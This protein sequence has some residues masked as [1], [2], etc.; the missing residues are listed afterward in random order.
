MVKMKK[1]HILTTL[2]I[3]LVIF[4]FSS[5]LWATDRS[6]DILALIEKGAI[7]KENQRY[8]NA[9]QKYKEAMAIVE[10]E[11]AKEPE[12]RRISLLKELLEHKIEQC[13]A[14]IYKIEQ[15]I[16]PQFPYK[17]ELEKV[18]VLIESADKEKNE[19]KFYIALKKYT[20]AREK[21]KFI[22]EN[23]P[24]WQEAKLL[25]EL[26]ERRIISSREEIIRLEGRS[27]Q[28]IAFS[29]NIDKIMKIVEKSSI[30]EKDDK[31]LIALQGYL[32]ALKMLEN[33]E[34]DYPH[35]AA[36]ISL[37]K[38]MVN[39]RIDGCRKKIEK[40]EKDIEEGIV[41]E[42]KV[43]R[44]P[45]PRAAVKREEIRPTELVEKEEEI[46]AEVE[47]EARVEVVVLEKPKP[48]LKPLL[49]ELPVKKIKLPLLKTYAKK[50]FEGILN[51]VTESRKAGRVEA[52]RANLANRQR[53]ASIKNGLKGLV[54]AIKGKI[55]EKIL[56]VKQKLGDFRKTILEK[57][58]VAKEKI[59]IPEE[60]KV[61]IPEKV[62]PEEVKP[63]KIVVKPEEVVK[64]EVVEE[65][66]KPE[67]VKEVKRPPREIGVAEKKQVWVK[68]RKKRP[69]GYDFSGYQL[70]PDITFYFE[71]KEFKFDAPCVRKGDEIWVPVKEFTGILNLVCL[72]LSKTS[73]GII[74]DDGT[75]LEMNL[76]ETDVLVN[77]KPF[78][79]IPRPLAIY[80][81]NFMLSLD[82]LQE[83]VGISCEYA[84][85]TNVVTITR[86]KKPKFTTFTVEKPPVS[87][88]EE[89]KRK[90]RLELIK[91]PR[92][93]REMREE[94]LP[95]EYYP[96]IDMKL[97]TS[98]RYFHD[99]LAE[100]RTRYNEYDLKGK[101]YGV[102]VFGHLSMRDYE[103]VEKAIWKEDGQHLS[104]FKEGRGLKL[105]D[106]Y[107]RLPGVR[108][109]SQSYWGA[110]LSDKSG[111]IKNA[112][113]GEMDSVYVSKIDGTGSVKYSGN[114]YAAKQD[115]ID[116][117]DFRLSAVELFTH[118]SPQFSEDKGTT[119]HPR[120]N[121]LYLL[122]TN[123]L[124]R[125]ALNLYNTFA[126]CTYVPDN[127]EDKIVSDYDIKTGM[128]FKHER[129]SVNSSV[130]YVG[131]KYASLGIPSTYQDYLG[132]Q[133]STNFKLMK[134][135]SLNISGN[136]NRD[137]VAFNEDN[138]TTHGRG[139]STSTNLRLPWDQ[140]VS[141]GW[142]YNR[143]ITRGG[144]Q[145]TTGNEYNSY[146]MDYYKTL[147]TASLQLGWQY[148]RMDPLAT[149]TG[150]MLFHTYS[151]TLYK[152]FP[153]LHG[154]YIR[155]YQDL[156][157]T[158]QLSMDG[159]PTSN[160][161][162]TSLS[163]RYYI[164]PYLSLSGNG[165]LRTTYQNTRNDA[166]IMSF[167]TGLDYNP[168]P[169]TNVGLTYE[170]GN[171]DLYDNRRTTKDWSFLFYVRHIFDFR[172][173]E[174]WGKIRVY[175]FEDLNGNDIRD[176]EEIGLEDVLAYIVE[177]RG[178]KTDS[179]GVALIK[180][181]VPG[182][183]KVRIDMRG[184]PVDMVIKGDPTK[185]V[186]VESL[187]TSETIFVIVT[188]GMVKGRLFVDT[189]KNGIFDKDVDIPIPNVGILLT[190]E[191]MGAISLSDGS[192]WF[193]YVYPGH[194]K[195]SI[196]LEDVPKE[197][198]LLSPE[199]KDIEVESKKTTENADFIFESKP[200]KIKYF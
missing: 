126:H 52:L 8:V 160:V 143:S 131:D 166:S 162:N 114:L 130:E 183:R 127:K 158:K 19:S 78:L 13:K 112:W 95:R 113:I 187:K 108:V 199:T 72:E 195:V 197:Y 50:P 2:V 91:K 96:D 185:E 62:I 11:L 57:R 180:K 25:L 198:R 116:R 175:V 155:L 117:D 184:L 56:R 9:L 73:I 173:P 15:E 153:N 196:N 138:R 115:W 188:T 76:G 99:M 74:K 69:T 48:E 87:P 84:P 170:V 42:K 193:E 177:G 200:L 139:I 33:L 36:R 3:L 164:L 176:V 147:G 27:D 6:E 189:D 152:S 123:W 70:D 150:S 54:S 125:P 128:K 55:K 129:F 144:Y 101:M 88:E 1:R 118:S 163:G 43:E 58:K 46:P 20:E 132:W 79:V 171:M 10:D 181:V 65:I 77:K 53:L 92:L 167:S 86:E 191:Y 140:S 142:G 80:N 107:L 148:Y 105:L 194:R 136:T 60:E 172:S 14:E 90:R 119:A 23:I 34:K 28:E 18:Y 17:K 44:K 38:E 41:I 141:C 134:N 146:R 85:D 102:D 149:S 106:N 111:L 159:L 7:D 71:G 110:E 82:S 4:G 151:T 169:A 59:V 12:N 97:N 45:I 137:N 94:S 192:Y 67:V 133:A 122:D 32:G 75:P 81:D 21:T 100:K 16:D 120:R 103:T 165:R 37:I 89:E 30:D 47:K 66:V 39:I 186:V 190:P 64:P 135:L 22:L 168:S 5:S 49:K 156:S 98:F 178:V 24:E 29:K 93:P 51:F 35:K 26:A 104:F 161:Y 174:K 61:V 31:Y 179:D 154:S 121:F 40:I 182:E 63:E 124:I 109:Q 83:A 145:D 157:R 68:A